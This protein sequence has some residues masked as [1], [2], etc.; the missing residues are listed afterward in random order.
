MIQPRRPVFVKS[1]Q[2][3][4]DRN[5]TVTKDTRRKKSVRRKHDDG[6]AEE[7]AV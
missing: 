6:G 5:L 2:N 7:T 1:V 3:D 4:G